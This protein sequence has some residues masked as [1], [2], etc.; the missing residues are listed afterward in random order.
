MS[1]QPSA[2]GARGAARTPAAGRA[3]AGRAAGGRPGVFVQAPKSDVYVAL[4]AVALVAMITGCV[5]MLLILKRYDFKL[6]AAALTSTTRALALAEMSKS[7]KSEIF[8][9]VRL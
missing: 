9:T 6:K 3:A 7:V 2:R 5:L 8:S 4:L 1:R